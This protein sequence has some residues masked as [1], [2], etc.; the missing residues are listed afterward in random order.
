MAKKHKPQRITFGSVFRLIIFSIIIFF[1]ISWLSQK[2]NT[3]LTVNDPTLFIGETSSSSNVLGD[4]YSKLPENSRQQLENFDQT[5]VGKFVS[6]TTEYIKSKLDGFPQKQIKEIKKG[7]I[8][9][10]SDD[11]IKTIDEK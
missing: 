3:N 11:M 1:L 6:N 7:I 4:M 8:K 2:P 10:I 5:Q 9:N